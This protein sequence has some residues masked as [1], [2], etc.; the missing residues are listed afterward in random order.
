MAAAGLD[1]LL[2]YLQSGQAEGRQAFLTGGTLE[3]DPLVNAAF[4]DA[5]FGA[6]L[7][8]SVTAGVQQAAW[9]YDATGWL[10]GLN[11]D[12]FFD[13]GYYLQHNQDV[14]AAHINPLVHCEASGWKDGRDPLAQFSTGKYLA[15]YAD[16]KAA[17]IDPLLH[18]ITNGQAE[19]RTA[20]PVC[21][22]KSG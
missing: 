21:G 9:S 10:K 3:A 12:A 22:E 14:A 6:T 1:P 16:V 5:Q 13:T 19:G 15:A 2:H 8:S 17:G 20:F 11:P 4:Y 18:Y 7:I